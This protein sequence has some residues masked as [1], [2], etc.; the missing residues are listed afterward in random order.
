MTF[1]DASN[2]A[3]ETSKSLQCNV[4]IQKDGMRKWSVICFHTARFEMSLESAANPKNLT[5]QISPKFNQQAIAR[6]N[7]KKIQDAVI[8]LCLACR[9]LEISDSQ[10]ILCKKKNIRIEF[11]EIECNFFR[12][13]R[14]D[15]NFDKPEVQYGEKIMY[16]NKI[17]RR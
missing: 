6:Q 15:K 3:K 4:R 5:I 13:A 16:F 9:R 11:G 17:K 14:A 2:Y 10:E 7:S 8:N 1:K 12:D